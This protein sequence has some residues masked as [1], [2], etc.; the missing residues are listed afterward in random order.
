MK[1]A[2]EE[3]IKEM[4][5]SQ[6]KNYWSLKPKLQIYAEGYIKACDELLEYLQ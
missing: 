4:K 3:K 5:E 1:E 2:L 6:H